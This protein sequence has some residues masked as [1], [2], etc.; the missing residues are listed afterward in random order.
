MDAGLL[1]QQVASLEEGRGFL[2]AS[3]LL[4][5]EVSGAD[6]EGWLNDLL[7]A[8]VRGI[9]VGT[10]E[11]SLLLSPTGRVRADVHVW[12]ALD[13]FVLVQDDRQ[14]APID[15][16]L[17]PYVLSSHVRLRRLGSETPFVLIRSGKGGWEVRDA[18]PAGASRVEGD[19][20]EAWRIRRGLPRFPVDID[21]DSLPAEAALDRLID[22]D[23]GC[24][25]GQ[26]AVAK[27]R[28]LGHPARVVLALKA[29]GV[30]GPGDR[31]LT[32]DEDVG[33]VTSATPVDTGTALLAR[34]R[35]DAR[36]APLHTSS[37]RTLEPA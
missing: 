14:P 21:Q 1:E 30:V 34:V 37:G 10:A 22:E 24:F 15:E 31:V 6:A 3:R 17:A 5:V 26:E 28:N 16:L 27:V 20:G 12:R 7:T 25:L 36:R 8:N 19:A 33:S 23:K 29:D 2:D 18:P 13:G 9:A 32:R 35:W 11:G 4:A